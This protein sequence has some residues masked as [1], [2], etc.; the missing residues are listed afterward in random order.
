MKSNRPNQSW[1]PAYSCDWIAICVSSVIFI[2]VIV[3][4]AH[5][6][7]SLSCL[8]CFSVVSWLYC[9]YRS[10]ISLRVPA[11][12]CSDYILRADHVQS[13]VGGIQ[14]INRLR[15]G[16]AVRIIAAR[17]PTGPIVSTADNS[18][19]WYSSHV[20]RPISVSNSDFQGNARVQPPTW[21]VQLRR[22]TTKCRLDDVPRIDVVSRYSVR[23]DQAAV[24]KASG[25]MVTWCPRCVTDYTQ[26]IGSPSSRPILLRFRPPQPMVHAIYINIYI[27]IQLRITVVDTVAAIGS[28]DLKQN[29]S[30]R[31]PM[32]SNVERLCHVTPFTSIN[33]C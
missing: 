16:L 7:Q 13:D 22:T 24:R 28:A 15:R 30:D 10:I 4:F 1:Y 29:S 12:L 8:S 26:I 5:G 27:Y 25:S 11:L 6:R 18:T 21:L 17:S 32:A 14:Y 23:H 20:L 33:G 31:R 2:C 9:E 3:V 19:P